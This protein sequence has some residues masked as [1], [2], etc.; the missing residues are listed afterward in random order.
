MRILDLFLLFRNPKT[1]I[2]NWY[3]S[4]QTIGLIRTSIISI[5]HRITDKLL[6]LRFVALC[7]LTVDFWQTFDIM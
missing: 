3:E 4:Q 7:G 5:G 1:R 6:G 2:R